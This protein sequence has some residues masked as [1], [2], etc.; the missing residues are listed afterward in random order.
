MMDELALFATESVQ[1]DWTAY[2]ERIA[3]ANEQAAARTMQRRQPS[4]DHYWSEQAEWWL[5]TLTNRGEL[6]TADDLIAQVGLPAGSANQVGA[7]FTAWHRAGLIEPVGY[8]QST[9]PSSNGRAVR[10]WR[11][12]R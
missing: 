12:T 11:V 2:D 6:I 9:R 5:K 3:A 7:R 8:V 1:F 10:Q 4:R